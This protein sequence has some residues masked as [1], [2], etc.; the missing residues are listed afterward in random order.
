[1]SRLVGAACGADCL[2]WQQPGTCNCK[3]FTI[4]SAPVT[5]VD[6]RA[7]RRQPTTGAPGTQSQ[8]SRPGR[9]LQTAA[10]RLVRTPVTL[11]SALKPWGSVIGASV[12]MYGP[13]GL[14]MFWGSVMLR[15]RFWV[16]DEAG[17]ARG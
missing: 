9:Q 15:N 1:M 3:H 5:Y 13:V 2:V 14:R 8:I 17:V 10:L 6:S 4:S 16:W 7:V 11:R 12:A